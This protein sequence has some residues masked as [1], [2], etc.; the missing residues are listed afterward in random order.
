MANNR[1]AQVSGCRPTAEESLSCFF[2]LLVEV[3]F[4]GMDG[5]QEH[6]ESGCGADQ[7]GPSDMH[8]LDSDTCLLQIR[9][10]FYDKSVR[11]L[12][13]IDTEALPQERESRIKR[14]IMRERV[15]R[16]ASAKGAAAAAA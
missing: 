7:P 2:H 8:F 10:P 12:T 13:L 1:P 15:G 6:T 14:E 16:M 5:S 9:E 11:Q 3:L 4:R